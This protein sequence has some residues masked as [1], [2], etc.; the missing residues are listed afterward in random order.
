MLMAEWVL[1]LGRRRLDALL[2]SVRNALQLLERPHVFA[3][4]SADAAGGWTA[5]NSGVTLEVV[6]NPQVGVAP[7]CDASALM[8]SLLLSDDVQANE[9]SP[10]PSVHV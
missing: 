4:A 8:H 3:R 10:E 2:R 6:G 7:H 9:R 1:A 5:M